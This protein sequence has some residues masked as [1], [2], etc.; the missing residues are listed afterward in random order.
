[1]IGVRGYPTAWG[2]VLGLQ[3]YIDDRFFMDRDDM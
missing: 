1:M 2:S 3:I